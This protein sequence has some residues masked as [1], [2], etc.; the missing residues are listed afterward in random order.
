M[1]RRV[2]AGFTS[3]QRSSLSV[4]TS[5]VSAAGLKLNKGQRHKDEPIVQPAVFNSSDLQH[6]D[7]NCTSM[8]GP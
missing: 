2:V 4:V 7:P 3:Q 1:W 8:A 6:V 5:M